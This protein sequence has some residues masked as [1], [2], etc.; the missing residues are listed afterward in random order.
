MGEDYG[1]LLRGINFLKTYGYD[2]NKLA[3]LDIDEKQLNFSMLPDINGFESYGSIINNNLVLVEKNNNGSY[4][5]SIKNPKSKIDLFIN[6][7]NRD[8]LDYLFFEICDSLICETEINCNG[9][10]IE[11]LEVV[12]KKEKHIFKMKLNNNML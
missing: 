4:I 6:I 11:S 12:N 9:L 8:H 7:K 10:G 1:R 3:V 2:I 5:L